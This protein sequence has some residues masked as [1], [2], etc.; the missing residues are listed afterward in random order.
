M[1][2]L[3]LI[4]KIKH[5]LKE[6]VE[7]VLLQ[8]I[9]H[10]LV[11][12]S[13]Q[14]VPY[15]QWIKSTT[16]SSVFHAITISETLTKKHYTCNIW[17]DLQ[18]SPEQS[19]PLLVCNLKSKTHPLPCKS[20]K[21]CEHSV[22]LA[23]STTGGGSFKSSTRPSSMLNGSLLSLV[24]THSGKIQ[25]PLLMDGNLPQFGFGQQPLCQ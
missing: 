19:N 8:P 20:C 25:A 2:V 24:L 12:S 16:F 21:F 3:P 9:I 10:W 15:T 14:V 5:F 1:K 23:W 18:H 6:A 22:S 7:V 11:C 4:I 17:N 13:R